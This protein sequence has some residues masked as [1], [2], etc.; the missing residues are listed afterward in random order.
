MKLEVWCVS[1]DGKIL[2]YFIEFDE[3]L[4]Y[5]ERTV[6]P[7]DN[8]ILLRTEIVVSEKVFEFVEDE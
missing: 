6:E 1:L 7:D 5:C 2:G 3:V 8:L 4:R